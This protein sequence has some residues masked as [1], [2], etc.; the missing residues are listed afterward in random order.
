MSDETNKVIVKENDMINRII[1]SCVKS[2]NV[3][4]ASLVNP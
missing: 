1:K 4:P 3:S 2:T